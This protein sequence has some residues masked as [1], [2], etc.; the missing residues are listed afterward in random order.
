MQTH[1]R[2]S[3]VSVQTEG[4][5]LP[6]DLLQRIA[7]RKLDGLGEA[8]YHVTPGQKLN[9]AI[10]DSWNRMLGAWTAFRSAASK[11]PES[12]AATSVT[13]ER[14]LLPL[15]SELGYGRLQPAKSIELEGKTY[16]IS[17]LW[18]TVP[19][20]LVGCGV[21]LD[22]RSP[23]VTGAS[24][25]PPHSMVQELLNRAE[26]HLWAFVSNGLRLRILRDTVSLTRQAYVEF[27]LETM[28]EGQAYSDFALLWLLC[29]ESRVEGDRPE[30]CWL[31]R[32][33]RSAQ[34]DGTRALDQ[35]RNGVQKAIEA[36]GLGFLEHSANTG[37]IEKL[38]SGQL[39]KQDYYRQLLRL[40]YRLLFL[41]AAED[42]GLLLNPGSSNEAKDLYVQHYSTARL[43]RLA[44]R[45]RGTRHS[46]LWYVLSLVMQKLG[47]D[48]GCEALALS[49]LGSFLWS[50]KA[51]PDLGGLQLTNG[52]LLEAVR[53]LAFTVD[54]QA[55]RPVDYRNL[56]AEELGSVYESL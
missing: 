18:G 38:R 22:K 13:R 7:N 12:D 40:V 53:E 39:D 9:E 4:A 49:A 6:V 31:E 15:F 56:G 51:I 52:A 24:R 20:H 48:S 55:R 44:E 26:G 36:L 27:D 45:K 3:F 2:N 42:R 23:G 46:D 35:L 14:W 11:L 10:S 41:F 8:D 16:P 50:S 5:I 43:R 25:T 29:H 19:I 32:W 1:H 37:L 30:Q 33:S 47:E 17:H 28:M 54:G 21:S 34:E